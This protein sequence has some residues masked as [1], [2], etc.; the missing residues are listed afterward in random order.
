[1]CI[2]DRMIAFE[3]ITTVGEAKTFYMRAV[4]LAKEGKMNEAEEAIGQGNAVFAKAHEHH[5][6]CIQKMCI[7]DRYP[8]HYICTIHLSQKIQQRF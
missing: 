4:N 8:I 7:R 5:F 3:M 6:S 2:R 1:M